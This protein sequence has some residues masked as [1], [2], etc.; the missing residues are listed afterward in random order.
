[1]NQTVKRLLIT[2]SVF[3]VLMGL[4]A[5]ALAVIDP[6]VR[7][8][9]ED[10]IAGEVAKRIE[11][12]DPK[13][14]TAEVGGF[15]AIAQVVTGAMDDVTVTAPGAGFGSARGDVTLKIKDLPVSPDA[16]FTSGTVNVVMTS[17]D[18]ANAIL[19]EEGAGGAALL[20]ESLSGVTLDGGLLHTSKVIDLYFTTVTLDVWLTVTAENNTFVVTPSRVAIN[21][22]ETS[23]EQIT[24][25][26]GD[27]A[28][29]ALAPRTFCAAQFF[30]KGMTLTDLTAG[31][32]SYTFDF[33][34][35]PAFIAD[36]DQRE[37]GTCA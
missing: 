16:N 8:R 31:E 33:D 11:I 17:E 20:D 5:G 35:N 4:L 21:G 9:V 10:T 27:F 6:W 29:A 19:G 28:G 18:L 32:G 14:V 7:D 24:A 3:V 2:L 1:M 15:S 23:V 36:A 30:P 12:D 22:A 13:S 34:L 26:Y 37:R 25:E